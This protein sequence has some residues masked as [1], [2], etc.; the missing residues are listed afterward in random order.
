MRIKM[1][2]AG[3]ISQEKGTAATS[4]S[5]SS[6]G[7]KSRQTKI[8][9]PRKKKEPGSQPAKQVFPLTKDPASLVILLTKSPRAALRSLTKKE[10][11]VLREK[12]R[13]PGCEARHSKYLAVVAGR[14]H[15]CELHFLLQLDHAVAETVVGIHQ[16]FYGLTGVDHGG[17]VPAAEMFAD[18]LE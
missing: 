13:M 15:C 6:G 10:A 14:L 17:V 18:G 16:V 11:H 8:T 12:K 2:G 7:R 3:E 9:N 5:K 4:A 1:T